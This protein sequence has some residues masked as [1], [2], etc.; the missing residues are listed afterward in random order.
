MAVLPFFFF[1]WTMVLL[2]PAM[3]LALYAQ[4]KVRRAY[5]KYSRVGS[6]IH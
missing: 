1:D 5:S 2:L 3:A 6:V 4:A